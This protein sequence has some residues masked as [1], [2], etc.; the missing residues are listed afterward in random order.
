MN[1]MRPGGPRAVSA[2]RPA[3]VPLPVVIQGHKSNFDGAR[4]PV[5]V[6]PAAEADAL[7]SWGIDQLVAV[8]QLLAVMASSAASSEVSA[9]AGAVSHLTAQA[10]AAVRAALQVHRDSFI[11]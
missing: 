10:E 11:D 6:N 7:M 5:I 3:V 8:N 1:A 9:L 2:L 4:A